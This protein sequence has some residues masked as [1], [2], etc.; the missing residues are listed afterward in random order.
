MYGR[1]KCQVLGVHLS[2]A[3]QRH[4]LLLQLPLAR[5]LDQDYHIT[6][7]SHFERMDLLPALE[8]AFE[9]GWGGEW[10]WFFLLIMPPTT[11]RQRRF[12]RQQIA[13]V[14]SA[15][16]KKNVEAPSLDSAA[17]AGFSQLPFTLRSLLS[18]HELSP[19]SVYDVHHCNNHVLANGVIHPL[20]FWTRANLP[21]E[22]TV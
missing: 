15:M 3:R 18:P 13:A 14:W 17:F 7:W 5:Y 6:T 2:Q 21:E 9:S 12:H 16:F 1:C 22:N 19:Q 10:S 8:K 4:Q 11:G 20:W